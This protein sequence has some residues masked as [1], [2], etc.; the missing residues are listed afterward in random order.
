ME[1]CVSYHLPL[2]YGVESLSQPLLGW[3]CGW[4]LIAPKF[5]SCFY[6]EDIV[7]VDFISRSSFGNPNSTGFSFTSRPKKTHPQ[8]IDTPDLWDIVCGCAWILLF[9]SPEDFEALSSDTLD[10]QYMS[11]G[12]PLI[13][14]LKS[15]PMH[16]NPLSSASSSLQ[17][18]LPWFFRHPSEGPPRVLSLTPVRV[19]L[20]SRVDSRS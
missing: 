15:H 20:G 9:S 2:K 12:N 16:P 4:I 8:V 3:L 11:K 18:P 14:G 6:G 10:F 5:G 1:T 17:T 7:S 19:M 13:K